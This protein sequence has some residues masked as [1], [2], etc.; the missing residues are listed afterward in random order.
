MSEP[1]P[2][3]PPPEVLLQADKAELISQ[4]AKHV[5][6]N[7]E[8]FVRVLLEQGSEFSFLKSSAPDDPAALDHAYYTNC[9]R[10]E[11]EKKTAGPGQRVEGVDS[12]GTERSAAASANTSTMA[13][14]DEDTG[15]DTE[16]AGW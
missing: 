7:G 16:L 5:A 14:R 1:R 11:L 10:Y 4:T 2:P 6:E 9:L 12:R 8:S 3:P 15:E 13:Q